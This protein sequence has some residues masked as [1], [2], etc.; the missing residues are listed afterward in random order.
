MLPDTLFKALS[1]PTRLRC[2][3]LLVEC[4]E[5]CVCELTHALALPQPKISHH[6]GTLRKS[7]IVSDRK[8]GLWNYYTI[9]PD[10]TDWAFEVLKTTSKGVSGCEPFA[11]DMIALLDM[12]NR[13]GGICSA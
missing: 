10:L 7:G 5:L 12:P 6:L 2:L 9:N 11:S 1:D 4:D 8:V 13:P 3:T